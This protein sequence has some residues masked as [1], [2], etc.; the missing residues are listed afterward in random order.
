MTSDEKATA[1]MHAAVASNDARSSQAAHSKSSDARRGAQLQ[2]ARA[3]RAV[4][5]KSSFRGVDYEFRVPA[6]Y[7]HWRAHALSGLAPLSDLAFA[8]RKAPQTDAERAA[9]DAWADAEARRI[10]WDDAP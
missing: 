2:A 10:L 6:D 3:P 7:P 9:F 4:V 8:L 1:A 5:L